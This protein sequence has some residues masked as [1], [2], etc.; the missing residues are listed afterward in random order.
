VIDWN[1]QTPPPTPGEEGLFE[2]GGCEQIDG[3]VYLLGGWFNY[4]GFTGY[5]VFTLVGDTPRGPFRADPV[6]YRLCGNSG[7]WVALWARFIRAEP[8]LL[9]NGYMYDGFTYETGD[10]YLPPIKKAVVDQGHLR[11]GYWSGNDRLKGKDWLIDLGR[12]GLV[13]PKASS[14]CTCRRIDAGI[15]LE[16]G[17]HVGSHAP[18]IR[19]LSVPTAVAILDQTVEAEKGLVVE[20]VVRVTTRDPR[21]VSPSVGFYLEETDTEG[22]AILLHAC[23][24]TEIGKMTLGRAAEFDVEDVIIP[25]CAAPAGIWPH[26]DHTFRLLV[27]RNMFELY[28]DE[29]FVQTFNTTHSPEAPGR[30]PKGVGFLVQNGQGYFTGLKAW[31]MTLGT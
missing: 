21:L 19:R 4:F 27:R 23:G 13:F 26:T 24:Q 9:I 7:R 12:V 15:E 10:T 31:Q 1:G 3:K 22:T 28:L 18:A 6:A 25:G 30:F 2:I 16:A 20:G 5:G 11:L 29:R 14:A 17:P 8:E